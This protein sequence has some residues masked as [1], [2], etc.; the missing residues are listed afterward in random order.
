MKLRLTACAAAFAASLLFPIHRS[1]AADRPRFAVIIYDTTGNPFWAKVVAGVDEAAKAFDV[2]ADTQFAN[3]DPV[4]QNNAIEAAMAAKV[5]GIVLAINV[6]NAY[7]ESIKRAIEAGIPVV[8]F[9]IDDPNGGKTHPRVAVG[10][11]WF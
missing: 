9:N 11:P 5:Q 6:P 7:D 1:L 8:A 10:G 4:Q 3:N 2:S